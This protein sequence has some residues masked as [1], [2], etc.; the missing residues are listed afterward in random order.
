MSPEGTES[1]W[2]SGFQEALGSVLSQDLGWGRVLALLCCWWRL[3]HLS[4]VKPW[5]CSTR[6]GWGTAEWL[7][8]RARSLLASLAAG[9]SCLLL[10]GYFFFHVQWNHPGFVSALELPA[11]AV[12]LCVAAQ[13]PSFRY[14]L[15]PRSFPASEQVEELCPKCWAVLWLPFHHS[16]PRQMLFHLPGVHLVFPSGKMGASSAP[17]LQWAG[18]G[19]QV[20]VCVPF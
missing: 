12:C 4:G 7:Q 1:V 3:C 5:S 20:G 11:A 9:I 13:V 19:G 17:H 16:I 10:V 18:S 2:D 8:G 14:S 6:E 15:G